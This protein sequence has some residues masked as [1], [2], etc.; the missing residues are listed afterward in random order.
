MSLDNS[1]HD[2]LPDATTPSAEA[3][4]ETQRVQN[5]IAR[6]SV[7]DIALYENW[8]SLSS[9]K[10]AKRAVKLATRGLPVPS[11]DRFISIFVA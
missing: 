9:K 7:A 2:E 8:E 1:P 10:K 11:E 3:L 4:T 5:Q 6:V